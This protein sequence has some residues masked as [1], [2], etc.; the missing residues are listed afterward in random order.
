MFVH[1]TDLRFEPMNTLLWGCLALVLCASVDTNSFGAWKTKKNSVRMNHPTPG[2]GRHAPD[3]SLEPLGPGPA[4][5]ILHSLVSLLTR[6]DCHKL[7][8]PSHAWPPVTPT[9]IPA[10]I[11]SIN[12]APAKRRQ[13]C[14]LSSVHQDVPSLLPLHPPSLETPTSDPSPPP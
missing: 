7:G 12:T 5:S 4:P 1:F 8:S 10:W 3:S 14:H 13:L 2:L 11:P 6:L 9:P